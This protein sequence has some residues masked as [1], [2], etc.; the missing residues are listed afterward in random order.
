MNGKSVTFLKLFRN[1]YAKVLRLKTGSLY[2]ILHL[3]FQN[4]RCAPQP[5]NRLLFRKSNTIRVLVIVLHIVIFALHFFKK[6]KKANDFRTDFLC[7]GLNFNTCID[8]NLW[9]NLS[10]QMMRELRHFNGVE[11]NLAMY[12]IMNMNIPP[13]EVVYNIIK[14]P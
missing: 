8:C 3:L 7:K 10:S 5:K 1:F 12:V 2:N 11:N 14:T 9:I 13:E 4:K 6:T